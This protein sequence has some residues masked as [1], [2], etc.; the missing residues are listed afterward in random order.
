MF[1]CKIHT[2]YSVFSPSSIQV[3]MGLEKIL[4]RVNI[5]GRI[6]LF[7]TVALLNVC[8]AQGNENCAK[9]FP[10]NCNSFSFDPVIDIELSGTYEISSPTLCE[11]SD[12][13]SIMIT[14][15]PG[16]GTILSCTA[17]LNIVFNNSQSIT[18]SNI[19]LVNCGGKINEIIHRTI[20]S[21]TSDF[22]FGKGTKY[23]LMFLYST[24]ITLNNVTMLNSPGYSIIALNALG[25]VELSNMHIS[26]STSSLDVDSGSG[27]AF[28]YV[29]QNTNDS[30]LKV[31]DSRFFNNTAIIPKEIYEPFLRQLNLGFTNDNITVLGAASVTIYYLQE[32]Y[33][34][35]TNISDVEFINNNGTFSGS[36]AIV[37]MHNTNIKEELS[38]IIAFSTTAKESE[39]FP[40]VT[41]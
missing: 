13:T 39:I 7:L 30:M 6:L 20:S 27:V 25:T 10:C 36:I 2:N 38:L 21:S 16:G 8:D 31:S 32:S 22:Y 3:T 23:A 40:T 15:S 26:N 24:N 33:N 1:A 34:V 19:T 28:L 17:G 29:D 11:L 4:P 35:I 9:R 12:K 5:V 18:I 37:Q 14:G 41:L